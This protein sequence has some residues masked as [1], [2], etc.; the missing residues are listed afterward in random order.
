MTYL[1]GKLGYVPFE[2][3]SQDVKSEI[4]SINEANVDIVSLNSNLVT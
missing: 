4:P 1:K 3:N 2:K